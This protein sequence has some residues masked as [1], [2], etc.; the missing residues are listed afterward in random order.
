MD[1]MA[2]HPGIVIDSQART[3]FDVPPP[4]A[5][6][7]LAAFHLAELGGPSLSL[8]SELAWLAEGGPLEV[9]VPGPGG[10]AEVYGEIADVTTLDFSTVT[11][12]DGLL[13]ATRV[14]RG[15]VR[16]GVRFRAHIRRTR[17]A[18]V[19]AVTTMLPALLLAARAE[20]VPRLVYAAE[21]APR[22]DVVRRVS[23]A[24][25]LRLTRALADGLV[26]CSEAVAAQFEGPDAPPIGVAYPPIAAGG[27]G[28]GEGLRARLGIEPSAPCVAVVGNISH[29]RGQDVLVRA[30]PSVRARL[31]ELRVLVVGDP[32]PRT[33]DVAYRDELVELARAL[34]VDDA[35]VFT[36]FVRRIGDVYAAA[37]AVAVPARRE[38]FGR[39]AAEAL[40]AGRP[41]VATR[42]G[43]VPEVVRAGTDAILVAPNDPGALA[44]GLIDVLTDEALR[45]RLVR[46][47]A[48]RVRREFSPERSLERFAAVVQAMGARQRRDCG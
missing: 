10:V 13:A 47:G 32:H 26:C 3:R 48:S 18:L 14:G 44:R 41:V 5:G 38:A 8:R 42:V 43:G 9:V 28:D 2:A 12:P 16:D 23:G 39:V 35:L 11:V 34:G 17:P 20:R 30:L 7:T 25:L 36:G 21:L 27:A 45:A 29:G 24:A 37:D 4:P 31:P 19:V 1:S 15:T 46:A 6:S 40:V 33:A 22:G